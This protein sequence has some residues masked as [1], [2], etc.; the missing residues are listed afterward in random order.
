[1]TLKT[2]DILIRSIKPCK[3]HSLNPVYLI[4]S[5]KPH[6]SKKTWKFVTVFNWYK[7]HLLDPIYIIW[8]PKP[9]ELK[10]TWEF[11]TA[12]NWSNLHSYDPCYTYFIYVRSWLYI[13]YLWQT[14]YFNIPLLPF[15]IPS[16]LCHII[17][18]RK[19]APSPSE[20]MDSL[21]QTNFFFFLR[22][23]WVIYVFLYLSVFLNESIPWIVIFIYFIKPFIVFNILLCDEA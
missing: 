6:E 5:L 14:S 22:F 15:N 12:F 18:K 9:Y 21:T 7:L 10:K 17:K 23:S 8:S 1:M 19:N 20:V 11:V 2:C 4:W 3:L 16:L 13:I